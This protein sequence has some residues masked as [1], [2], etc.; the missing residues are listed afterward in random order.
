MH[1]NIKKSNLKLSWYKMIFENT[2]FNIFAFGN[3]LVKYKLTAPTIVWLDPLKSETWLA[4]H[5]AHCM[6]RLLL[7]VK[8]GLNETYD[9]TN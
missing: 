6:K 8:L 9:N 1:E 3:R 4:A 5:F 7:H 2:I